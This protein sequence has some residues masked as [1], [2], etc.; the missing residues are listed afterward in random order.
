MRMQFGRITLA[1]V[2][3]G[4]IA[5]P[6]MA[7]LAGQPVYAIQKGTG[8]SLNADLGVNLDPGDFNTLAGRAT[9]GLPMVSFTV[10]FEPEVLDGFENQIMLGGAVTVLPL[11]TTS[12]RLQ[13]NVGY[14][15][16]SETWAVPIGVVLDVRP[17]TP[18][19]S[20]NPWVFPQFRITRVSAFG[21]TDTQTGL[22]ISAGLSLGLPGGLGGHVALDYDVESEVILGGIGVH[23]KI[24]VPGLGMVPG[25]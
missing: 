2:G 25:M 24:S 19:L 23:Y 1:V 20:V 3:L 9:L 21:I 10:G 5:T 11:P 18:A 17:P 13:A 14:G 16:D 8:V 7:Q 22:G 12:I 6:A 4:I 15:L